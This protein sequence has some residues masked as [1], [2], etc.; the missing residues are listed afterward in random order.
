MNLTFISISTAL[1]TFL[2]AIKGDVLK[3][4]TF[5]GIQLIF[6]IILLIYANFSGYRLMNYSS[7]LLKTLNSYTFRAGFAFLMNAM[8]L[9]MF[10]LASKILSL[11]FFLSLLAIMLVYDSILN[12]ER[13]MLGK[14]IK[15]SGELLSIIILLSGLL[16]VFGFY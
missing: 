7:S 10:H 3:N 2:I 1:F 13:Y 14:K 8:G 15:I 12:Y 4:D 6:S 9:L 11:T 16:K 5:L